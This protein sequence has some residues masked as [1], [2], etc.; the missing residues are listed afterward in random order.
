ML[1]FACFLIN[2][3]IMVVFIIL[4]F[5]N[6]VLD[7]SLQSPFLSEYKMHN[8][9]V[10]FVHCAI[11]GIG[12]SIALLVFGMFAWWKLAMLV[13]GHYVIDYWKC[14][15]VYEKWPKKC[16]VRLNGQKVPVFDD[17]GAYYADQILHVIQILICFL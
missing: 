10:L 6:L 15:K 7:Y 2:Q 1:A 5:I 12:L 3:D 14:R 4:Y 8:N 11:W 17:Y 16:I 13:I 9:Y